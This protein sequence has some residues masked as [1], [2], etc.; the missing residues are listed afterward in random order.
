MTLY[1]YSENR[2]R[3]KKV[4]DSKC[5]SVLML[6]KQSDAAKILESKSDSVLILK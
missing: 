1:Q 6:R 2:G 4:L 5:D 3:L